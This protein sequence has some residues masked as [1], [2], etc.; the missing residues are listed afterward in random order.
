M[1]AQFAE[2]EGHHQA[3]NEALGAEKLFLEEQLILTQ[4]ERD[5]FQREVAALKQEAEATWAAERAESAVMRE[6]INDVAAEVAR[7]TAVLEGPGSPIEAILAGEAGLAHSGPAH[8]APNGASERGNGET[9]LGAITAHSE[10][11]RSSLADRIRTLQNRRT[12]LA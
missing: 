5:R 1:Y 8:A 11:Q 6:R 3:V 10:S 9:L 7:L 2:R 12:R 4:Q